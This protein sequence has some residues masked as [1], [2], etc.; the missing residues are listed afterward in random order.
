MGS[1][2]PPP[3]NWVL[4]DPWGSAPGPEPHA[5]DTGCVP[6]PLCQLCPTGRPQ[7]AGRWS[8][9]SHGLCCADSKASPHRAAH[10]GSLGLG[11]CIVSSEADL[12]DRP[13]EGFIFQDLIKH[14]CPESET[15]VV[16]PWTG[17]LVQQ[18]G[19]AVAL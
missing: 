14:T 18:T 8:P 10:G 17:D 13:L 9:L 7:G 6:A 12:S 5:A 1:L 2:P 11:L 15:R 16:A 4:G 3:E 19:Q